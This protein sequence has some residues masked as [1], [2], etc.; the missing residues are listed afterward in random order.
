MRAI[1]AAACL[2]LL[3]AGCS[4]DGAE[5]TTAPTATAPVLGDGVLTVGT[6]FPST[7][8]SAFIGPAQSAGVAVAIAEINEAGGV[9]GKPVQLVVRDSGEAATTLLETSFSELVDKDVDVVIGPSSSVLA[10]RVVPL[11]VAAGIPLI[12]PAATFPQLT[13]LGDHGLFFRTIPAYGEQGFALGKALSEGG[14]VTVALLYIDDEFG[15]ALAPTLTDSVAAEGSELVLSEAIPPTTTDLAP[16]IAKLVAAA[17]DA[18]V[19]GS[20]YA[21]VD[22]TK[23]LVSAV[24]AA[25]FGGTKLWLTTQNTG[26]YSQAL[27]GGTLTGVNGIIEGA[28]PDDAF[29]AR[30][31]GVD[32]SLA[33]FRYATEAYDATVLAALAA[34]VAGDDAGSAVAA[35]LGPVSTR[36]IKC[37]SFAECL[38]VLKTQDD[39]DYDGLSGPLNFTPEG[40]VSPAYY[41]IY[42]YDGENRF[43]FRRGIVAG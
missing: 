24:V 9:N 17:P 35:S 32:G 16:V 1:I 40:D 28:V 29:I 7:G 2:T 18:V 4:A 36:G 19:L 21:S 26:D 41:G 42:S 20:T 3:L 5:P 38:G 14:P 39:I 22:A 27:P 15:A 34:E 13:A 43:A 23:A 10:Q 31:K 11:A 25:G 33:A 12:S 6:L 8:A 30:L 37:T